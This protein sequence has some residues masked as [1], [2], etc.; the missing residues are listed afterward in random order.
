M[1]AAGLTV[2]SC[3]CA[4]M[5]PRCR[6]IRLYQK[7]TQLLIRKAPFS[8]VV[9]E[10]LQKGGPQGTRDFRITPDAMLALQ[11]A[12]E[13]FCVSGWDIMG[14]GGVGGGMRE[15][16]GVGGGGVGVGGLRGG[17]VSRAVPVSVAVGPC[18]GS[19][20]CTVHAPQ[21]VCNPHRCC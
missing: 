2:S 11:E 7:S 19:R 1:A 10:I 8:R 17:S 3:P 18:T 16:E 9:R 4:R 21:H 20:A 13:A 5:A 12:A 15:V 6:E 14:P